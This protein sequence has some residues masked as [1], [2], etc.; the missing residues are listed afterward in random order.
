VARAQ[1]PVAG[2]GPVPRIDDT[3]THPLQDRE[4]EPKFLEAIRSALVEALGLAGPE[5]LPAL[6]RLPV[7][8]AL[9]DDLAASLCARHGIAPG[10]SRAAAVGA[11]VER[12]RRSVQYTYALLKGETRYDAD[13]TPCGPIP[14]AEREVA[15]SRFEHLKTQQKRGNQKVRMTQLQR[16]FSRIPG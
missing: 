3:M 13:M 12:Y 1:H 14:A 10:D 5:A 16:Q 6:F 2:R 9:A 7:A 8:V 15:R 11:V 4:F